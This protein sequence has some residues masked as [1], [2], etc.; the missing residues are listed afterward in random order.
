MRWRCHGVSV[1]VTIE[2]ANWRT[3]RSNQG[4]CLSIDTNLLGLLFNH[5]QV[6]GHWPRRDIC[7]HQLLSYSPRRGT[8]RSAPPVPRQRDHS[9]RKKRRSAATSLR[10]RRPP[11]PP[12]KPAPKIRR[13]IPRRPSPL[14]RIR[15]PHLP[16]SIPALTLPP[17]RSP[18]PA[19]TTIISA[20][21][22]LRRGVRALLLDMRSRHDLG[23]EVQP[24]AQV[25]EALGREGVVVPLPG[26]LGF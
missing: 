25:V 14:L 16:P 20:H 17:R 5:T 8:A 3:Q 4:F 6:D 1:T 23:G 13:K 19:R 22:A 7:I 26:E 2:E 9:T 15:I 18:P 10:S 24:F 12:P 11:P 21:H